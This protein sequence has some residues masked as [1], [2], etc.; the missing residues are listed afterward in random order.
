[1]KKLWKEFR[2]TI[3]EASNAK[4]GRFEGGSP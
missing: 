1:V 4:Q 2:G 3:D